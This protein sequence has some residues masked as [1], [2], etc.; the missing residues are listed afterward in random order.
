L[1][2]IALEHYI[3]MNCKLSLTCASHEECYFF[4]PSQIVHLWASISV[5]T[6]L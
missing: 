1:C 3:E 6:L 5:K 2:I 4:F